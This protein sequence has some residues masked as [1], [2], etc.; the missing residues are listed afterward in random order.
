VAYKEGRLQTEGAGNDS[1]WY[2]LDP[3]CAFKFNVNNDDTP[4]FISVIPHLIDL[5]AA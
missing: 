3:D 4:P 1:G 5:D 2:L